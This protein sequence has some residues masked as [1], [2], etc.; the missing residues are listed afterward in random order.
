MSKN[1]APQPGVA[2]VNMAKPVCCNPFQLGMDVPYPLDL[3]DQDPYQ[4]LQQIQSQSLMS[5]RFLEEM[6]RK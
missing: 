2:Q 6:T 3:A 5:V 1:C 4:S